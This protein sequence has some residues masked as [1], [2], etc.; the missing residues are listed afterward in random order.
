MKTM[1]ITNAIQLVGDTYLLAS[2]LFRQDLKEV[3]RST[4]L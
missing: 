2:S 4:D 1:T 3:A